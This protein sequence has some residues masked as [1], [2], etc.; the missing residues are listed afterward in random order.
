MMSFG[1]C[2][3]LCECLGQ[4]PG[5]KCTTHFFFENRSFVDFEIGNESVGGELEEND[6]FQ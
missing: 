1:V 5:E 6:N 4:V 3:P 2:V